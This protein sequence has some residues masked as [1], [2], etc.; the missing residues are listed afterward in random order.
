MNS[1]LKS[2]LGRKLIH[3]LFG[4]IFLALIYFDIIGWAELSVI[5]MLSIALSLL[6]KKYK[7]PIIHQ[8][9]ENFEKEE[10][11]KNMPGKGI[12]YL[13]LGMLLSL[14]FFDKDI[15]LA[16]IA[17]ITFGDAISHIIG[18]NYGKT[19][20][21]LNVSGKKLIE[22]SIAGT[23]AAFFAAWIFIYWYAAAIGAIIG[24]I[25]EAI[26]LRIFQHDIDDNLIVP[27][28]AGAAMTVVRIF[29]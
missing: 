3:I 21:P 26:E 5:F 15:A 6:S 17:I 24:M 1:K 28:F 27:V 18:T 19:K 10:H 25:F 23:I 14:I 16:S 4:S 7:I 20:H 13:L 29:L 8:F 22:G 11:R 12:I 9:L 2:E